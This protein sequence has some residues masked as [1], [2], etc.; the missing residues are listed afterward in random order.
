[1]IWMLNS[2]WLL[3]HLLYFWTELFKNRLKVLA[4]ITKM[5]IVIAG[6]AEA[7]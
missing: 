1:M 3:N 7:A 5:S 6:R 4:Q 2:L